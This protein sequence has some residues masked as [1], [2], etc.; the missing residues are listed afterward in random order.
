LSH[1]VVNTA[2]LGENPLTINPLISLRLIASNYPESRTCTFRRNVANKNVEQVNIA[3]RGEAVT[4]AERDADY[5]IG[6]HSRRDE[7]SRDR[8]IHGLKPGN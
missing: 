8:S 7:S 4:T 2:W 5:D 6:R 1:P 3:K